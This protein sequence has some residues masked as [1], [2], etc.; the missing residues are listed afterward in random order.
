MAQVVEG[1]HAQGVG[2]LLLLRHVLHPL[3]IGRQPAAAGG[4]RALGGCRRCLLPCLRRL[5]S[6]SLGVFLKD[7]ARPPLPLLL[8]RH[9][10]EPCHLR[11]RQARRRLE[12][13]RDR[14]FRG[15]SKSLEFRDLLGGQDSRAGPSFP[16][17]ASAATFALAAAA[18]AAAAGGAGGAGMSGGSLKR[19]L[20]DLRPG[21]LVE[22][23]GL[24]LALGAPA[25]F[26]RTL[27]VKLSVGVS[28]QAMQQAMMATWLMPEQHKAQLLKA[29]STPAALEAMGVATGGSCCGRGT[30]LAFTWRASGAGGL[31]VRVNGELVDDLLDPAAHLEAQRPWDAGSLALTSKASA[32]QRAY[33]D[34]RCVTRE[35][36]LALDSPG[37][38]PVPEAPAAP[39]AA[40]VRR[41]RMVGRSLG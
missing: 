13:V 1:R 21:A 4:R 12:L 15:S 5:T 31:E 8:L 9:L 26:D 10:G 40:V 35:A 25:P 38:M 11:R 22:D 37:V 20:L 32:W 16:A 41:G 18:A 2:E 17:S 3:R 6:E 30:D 28:R 27:S 7:E 34:A 29:F 23:G 36:A 14:G 24:F 33:L 19:A 39:A